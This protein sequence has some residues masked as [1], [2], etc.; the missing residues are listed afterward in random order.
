[1]NE[2][3]IW[4]CVEAKNVFVHVRLGQQ[5]FLS[6]ARDEVGSQKLKFE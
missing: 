2:H 4:G 6:F 3:L 5:C 1:M